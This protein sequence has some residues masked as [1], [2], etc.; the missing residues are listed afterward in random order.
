MRIPI[1]GIIGSVDDEKNTKLK[2]TYV[3]AI[4]FCGGAPILLPYVET[5]ESIKRFTENCDGFLLTGGVDIHPNRYGEKIKNKCGKIQRH[6]D[7]LEFRAFESI[8]KHDKPIMAICRGAQL[9]NVALGG[10][11]H[12]DINDE[13]QTS[14]LHQQTEPKNAYSHAVRIFENTPL[15]NLI[16]REK[17]YT[18]SFHHQAIKTLGRGLKIMATAEDGVIEAVYST[19][20]RYIRAYQWH[21]ELL[22]EADTISKSV[23]DDFITECQFKI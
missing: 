7:I 3:K 16:S 19:E 4:E 21:P 2:N 5:A 14:I 8:Y 12:Q 9:V 18:N 13:I 17:I 22:V 6:R 15:F 23:F 10:N 1:V 20:K 11:L